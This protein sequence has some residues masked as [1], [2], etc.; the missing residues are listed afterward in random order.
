MTL[1]VDAFVVVAGLVGGGRVGAWAESALSSGSLAA[2]HLMLVEAANI[3]RSSALA[4]DISH[5]VASLAHSDLV[6]LPVALFPYPT[7]ASRV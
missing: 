1:V 2:P 5:D 6:S 4:G 7:F 3:L